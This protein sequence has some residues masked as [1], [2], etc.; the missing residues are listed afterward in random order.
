MNYSPTSELDYNK[1]LEAFT[2][3]ADGFKDNSLLLY[4]VLIA[5]QLDHI[6]YQG[7]IYSPSFTANQKKLQLID[8]FFDALCKT[9]SWPK[10]VE[11]LEKEILEAGQYQHYR[12]ILM[13]H[14][15]FKYFQP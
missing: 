9:T 15:L 14:N 3:L 6:K 1:A 5:F 4:R 10:F 7:L 2:V 12:H 13:E 8:L 11:V